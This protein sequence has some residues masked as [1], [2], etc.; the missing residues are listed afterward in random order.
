MSVDELNQGV[1]GTVHRIAQFLVPPSMSSP[2]SRVWY[3]ENHTELE[4]SNL[5]VQQRMAALFNLHSRVSLSSWK[6]V[7]ILS[8]EAQRN[9]QASGNYC[10]SAWKFNEAQQMVMALLGE[11]FQQDELLFLDNRPFCVVLHG[12]SGVGK[13]EFMIQATIQATRLNKSVLILCATG[14][15]LHAYNHRV[16][17]FPMVSIET[18]HA[19]RRNNRNDTTR[20]GFDA[21]MMDEMSLVSNKALMQSYLIRIQQLFCTR[22]LNN[23]SCA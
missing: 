17:S 5:V 23:I 2:R 16:S 22:H 4:T 18:L 11:H 13:T 19:V 8:M 10:S 15:M 9:F 14:Q 7:Y 20:H 6:I 1:S 21:I 12:A 3:T